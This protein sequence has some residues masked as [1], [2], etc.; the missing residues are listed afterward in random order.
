MVAVQTQSP[1]PV[2][3]VVIQQ[4]QPHIAR[5][6]FGGLLAFTVL[7]KIWSALWP[8]WIIA[9]LFILAIAFRT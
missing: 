9:I 3:Q 6:V 5:G 4:P 1:P 2:Y 8:G 7:G